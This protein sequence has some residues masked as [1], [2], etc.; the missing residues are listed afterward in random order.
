MLGQKSAVVVNDLVQTWK[1]GRYRPQ[2]EKA[3]KSCNPD[4]VI[5]AIR[6]C[7]DEKASMLPELILIS[8]EITVKYLITVIDPN[9]WVKKL[10]AKT[11][12][13]LQVKGNSLIFNTL[14]EC[15][16]I[17]VT[18]EENVKFLNILKCYVSSQNIPLLL[19]LYDYYLQK[20]NKKS[21]LPDVEGDNLATDGWA[22]RTRLVER[23]NPKGVNTFSLGKNRT[24]D[25]ARLLYEL[26]FNAKIAIIALVPFSQATRMSH[27]EKSSYHMIAA[28]S[29]SSI[30]TN[31]VRFLYDEKLPRAAVEGLNNLSKGFRSKRVLEA[32]EQKILLRCT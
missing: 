10:L 1:E 30:T 14:Q 4:L 27:M 19:E 23:E 11:P 15:D 18:P 31:I 21:N 16:Q 20:L 6:N 22:A 28:F 17:C 9:P 5:I 29:E 7:F 12:C 2:I 13:W 8:K 32:A 25:L 3:L 24:Q 26:D